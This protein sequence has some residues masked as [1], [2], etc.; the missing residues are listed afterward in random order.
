MK[1]G[2]YYMKIGYTQEQIN[3]LEFPVYDYE[4]PKGSGEFQGTMV[5][6]KWSEKKCL[7]CYF[8]T[9]DGEELKI[10]VWYSENEARSYRPKQSDVDISELPLGC[11]LKVGYAPTSTKKT[12]WDTVEVLSMPDEGEEEVDIDEETE[13]SSEESDEM[14]DCPLDDEA[15]VKEEEEEE[16]GEG[17]EEEE[18]EE[19]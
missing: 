9:T 11:E 8:D 18:E 14:L 13:D 3:E 1:N 16:E 2:A 4:F 6:K 10:C 19:E 12:R 17:E 7:I 5:M 15:S